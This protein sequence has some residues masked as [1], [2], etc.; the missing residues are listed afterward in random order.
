MGSYQPYDRAGLDARYA[1]A[2]QTGLTLQVVPSE[3]Y[4]MTPGR[5][6]IVAGPFDRDTALRLLRQVRQVVPDAFRNSLD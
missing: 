2:Q 1:P 3:T 6:V 4:G 5:R